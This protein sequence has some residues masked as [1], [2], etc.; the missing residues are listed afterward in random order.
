MILNLFAD[1]PDPTV[2]REQINASLLELVNGL[3]KALIGE[4]HVLPT[5]A[6]GTEV[7]LN[8]RLGVKPLVVLFTHSKDVA[9]QIIARPSRAVMD[10]W[11]DTEVRFPAP[12][13]FT[14]NVV[15]AL[16]VGSLGD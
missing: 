8:H 5:L 9:S 12:T 16:V 7:V 13:K 15:T 3:N 11:T 6:T 10:T 1:S 2:L 4:L 14:G